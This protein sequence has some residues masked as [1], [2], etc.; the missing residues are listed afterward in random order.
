MDI[1]PQTVDMIESDWDYFANAIESTATKVK[2]SYT[3]SQVLNA[4]STGDLTLFYVYE[5]EEKRGLL[6]LTD[7]VDR[8]TRRKV[9]HVDIMYTTG[10]SLIIKMNNLLSQIVD[11]HK[12]DGIE[13][14]SPRKG[15]HKYLTEAGFRASSIF[16]KEFYY[17]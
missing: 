2:D 10:S 6:A 3:P 8:Y 12:F 4:V 15:W 17:E 14:R 5:D 1:V 11:D 16:S 9:L 13:F 7:H